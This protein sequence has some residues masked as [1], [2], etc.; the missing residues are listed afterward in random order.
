[1]EQQTLLLVDDEPSLLK[2]LQRALRQESYRI[3][4]AESGPKALAILKE[5]NVQLVVSDYKM[6]KMD[7]LTLL[8]RIRESYPHIVLIM[9]TGYADMGVLLQAINEVGM[10]KFFL[11]PISIDQFR[12]AINAALKLVEAREPG[13]VPSS[14][15]IK[16]ILITEL[17]HQYPGITNLPPRD[18]EGYYIIASES[19]S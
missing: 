7:G 5:Q 18:D 19:D 8:K 13:S 14:D 2:G 17:E 10:F 4:T 15:N 12:L 11:K 16:K 9:L 3:L 6:L 1:M